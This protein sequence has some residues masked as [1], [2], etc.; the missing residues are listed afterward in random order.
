MV[1][2]PAELERFLFTCVAL[3]FGTSWLSLVFVALPA[4]GQW[5]LATSNTTA[6]LRGVH[7]AGVGVIWAS[8]T[9]GTVLRSE[10]DGY[11]WQLCATPPDAAK[12]DFR[13]VFGWNGD[14][15]VVMSSGPGPAS[16][17]YE[18]KDGCA[19]WRVLFQNPD[20]DGFW[21]A[22]VFRGNTA[23]ILGDPVGGRFAIYR[24]DDS[25]Q[26]WHRDNALGLAASP[27]GEG[28]FAASNS[29]LVVLPNSE[30]LFATGGLGGPRIFRKQVSEGWTGARMPIAGHKESAGVFS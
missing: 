24:S 3:R 9:N 10:D 18:T 8:G 26:H 6:D 30:L 20:P 25:G 19:T 22:L 4:F 1:S 27:E 14:H 16:R 23:F 28:A 21:D 11:V 13:A 7:K 15:A 2:E 12:L 29:S 17:L 5:N